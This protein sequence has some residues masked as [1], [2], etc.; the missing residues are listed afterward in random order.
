M[1]RVLFRRPYC[2][3]VVSVPSWPKSR[4]IIY[5]A[6]L[7]VHFRYV[8]GVVVLQ[9][10]WSSPSSSPS[11]SW[12]DMLWRSSTPA[13][14]CIPWVS[15]AAAVRQKQQYI[16]HLQLLVL[17]CGRDRHDRVSSL[18]PFF[19]TGKLRTPSVHVGQRTFGSYKQQWPRSSGATNTLLSKYTRDMMQVVI[20]NGDFQQLLDCK[21]ACWP[22][23]WKSVS[24]QSSSTT[25][26]TTKEA[27]KQ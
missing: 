8:I 16:F 11:S 18:Y 7:V 1:A 4:Y 3:V 9:F 27:T 22:T 17:A 13:I 14:I 21:N 10:S 23:A 20:L 15:T 12:T 19:G 6:R 5:S 25:A 24:S 26:S 2:A